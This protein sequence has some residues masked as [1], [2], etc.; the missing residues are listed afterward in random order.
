[1]K[2]TVCLIIMVV[3]GCTMGCVTTN[4]QKATIEGTAIGAAGGAVIGQLFGKN[5]KSTLIGAAAG[6]AIGGLISYNLASDLDDEKKKLEG[7]ENDLDARIQYANAVNEKTMKYNADLNAQIKTIEAEV[8]TGKLKKDELAQLNKKLKED[9]SRLNSELVEL[10][11][12][13]K[14]LMNEQHPQNKIDTLDDQ[15]S[16]LQAQLDSLQ[17]NVQKIAKL[18]RRVKA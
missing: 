2:K 8:D 3:F 6:A 1:M 4:T 16:S 7:R 14:S 11:K 18:N 12:Y 5:T 15:I 9:Q 13:R 10:K 17:L